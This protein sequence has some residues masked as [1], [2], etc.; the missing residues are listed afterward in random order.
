MVKML[1]VDDEE[2]IREGICLAG[3]WAEHGIEVIGSAENGVEALEII[4]TNKP[5][6]ILTDVVMPEMDGI[7]LSRVIYEE[8]PDIKI[9]LLSGYNDFQYARSALEFR[10]SNYLLKPAKLEVLQA[11]V[12][13]LKTKIEMEAEKRLK[14]ELMVQ[15]LER[16]LPLLREQ[17]LNQIIYYGAM[18]QEKV[19]TEF[20]YLEIELSTDNTG[21]MVL[22]LDNCSRKKQYAYKEEYYITKLKLK[23]LCSNVMEYGNKHVIFEDREERTVILFNF[24]YDKTCSDN[25]ELIMKKAEKIQKESRRQL[26]LS[27]SAGIGRLQKNANGINEAYKEAV[28]ALE[29][30]F[31]MGNESVIYIGD[32]DLPDNFSYYYPQ[33]IESDIIMNVR[34]GNFM[35][36]CEL[37]ESFFEELQAEGRYKPEEFLCEGLFLLNGISRVTLENEREFKSED[38]MNAVNIM[39]KSRDMH[40]N[41]LEELKCYIL[42]IV[43]KITDSINA[44]RQLRNRSLIQ[45][46]KDYIKRNIGSDIS[47]IAIANELYISPNY[48]SFLFK[49]E[50]GENFKDYMLKVKMEKAKELLKDMNFT[51]NQIAVNIGYCDGRYFSHVFKKYSG[52]SPEEWRENVEDN[53]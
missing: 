48:L 49:E 34:A 29:Y 33:H 35:K 41:T 44:N 23:E 50:A 18:D 2:I 32:V 26:G 15:K 9:I 21:V 43:K 3:E 1:V 7:E 14:D 20:D 22:Q 16:S 17:Y 36:A 53:K 11:E 4:R 38:S 8:F 28:S 51:L 46:A 24:S 30:K 19:Q 31:Y 52:M 40:F 5:D 12:L 42:N 45:N 6:I 37:V 47:L 13:K 39:L 10:V 25:I 27:M